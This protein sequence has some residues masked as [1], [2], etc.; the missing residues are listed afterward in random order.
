MYSYLFML[1]FFLLTFFFLQLYIA[2]QLNAV[3]V[4]Y[5]EASN[6]ACTLVNRRQV[7]F[8]MKCVEFHSNVC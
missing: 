8:G 1:I 2:C 6:K 3:P 4:N 7:L 5:A